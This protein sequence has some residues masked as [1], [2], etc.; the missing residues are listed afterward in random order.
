LILL[1]IF[2]VLSSNLIGQTVLT[3]IVTDT[4]NN[5]LPFASVYLSKTTMGTLTDNAGA[6]TI[7]IPQNSTYE[8]IVSCM[9]Y[10]SHSQMFSV[11]GGRQKIDVR[12][13]VN[14][15]MLNEVT[16]RSREK[17]WL[18]NYSQFVKMFLGETVNSQTCKIKNPGD[19]HL[20]IDSDMETLKG[21]SFKPLNIENRALGY[22]II[23]DLTDFNYNPRTGLLRFSGNHYFQDMKANKTDARKWRRNRLN[24]YYGSRMHFMRSLFSN[25]LVPEDFKI[26]EYEIVDTAKKELALNKPLLANDLRLSYDKS[27]SYVFF[28]KPVM[29]YFKDDHPELSGSLTGFQPQEL[30]STILFTDTVNVFSNG[31]FD[32][33]YSITWGGEM[34]NERIGDLLPFDFQPDNSRIEINDSDS[35]VNPV[36]KYLLSEQNSRSQDQIFVHL[37]RNMY[38][39]GDTIYFQAYIRNRFTGEFETMSVSL[40]ALL[41]NEEKKTIDS[42]RFKIGNSLSSGWMTM[43]PKAEPGQYHFVAFTS[44]MQNYGQDDAFHSDLTVRKI[45]RITKEDNIKD[46]VVDSISADTTVENDFFSL[47]FLPEGGNLVKGTE[48]RIGFNAVDFSGEPV[49]FEGLLKDTSGLILDTIR[50]GPYGPGFFT[51]NPRS[52]MYVEVTRGNEKEKIW[53]LP[54][55]VEAIACLSVS[56][57]GNRSFAVEIQSSDYKGQKVILSG[58]MNLTQIFYQEITLDKKHRIIVNTDQLPSGIVQVTLFTKEMQPV[59]ERLFYVNSDKNLKFTI[60][61]GTDIYR[62]G[63]ETELTIYVTDGNGQP[64]EGLFS[65]SVSDSILGHDARTFIPGIEYTYNYN[66]C[67][68]ANLPSVVLSHGLGNISDE[69][70]DL[71]MMVYG[72]SR[73]NWDFNQEKSIPGELIN[74]D[75]LKMKI[76][77]TGKNHRSDRR[78]D[79][80]SLEGPSIK[81]LLTNSLGEISLP[82]DSL[83]EITRSFTLMPDPKNKKRVTGAMFS[84]PYNENFFKSNLLLKAQPALIRSAFRVPVAAQNI[85]LGEEPIEIQEVIIK[86][87]PGTE[88]LYHDNYEETYQYADIRS[89]DYELLWSS[90]TIADAVR[91]LIVP[92]FMNDNIVV[93][94]P[95]RSFFGGDLPALIVLDGMPLYDN[96]WASVKTISTADVTSLTILPGGQASARYGMIAAGGVI[97]INTKSSDPSLQK[98]R[99]EWKLQHSDNKMLLPISL[100]RPEKDFYS[101]SRSDIETDPILRSRATIFWDP[102]VYFN[103]KEPIHLRFTNLMHQGPVIV[104]INGASTNNLVG[105]GKASYHVYE[106]A[107]Q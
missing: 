89:L 11:E 3:G 24:A 84:I 90:N 20:Y 107:G 10:K 32:N 97:F 29:I 57:E 18:N 104:T 69:D 103:G 101:P 78:L 13:S 49:W 45:K 33:S 46:E 63:Q 93:L 35:V 61:K 1:L 44:M 98:A 23:Y 4:L 2:L 96:G 7:N 47:R 6:Y 5:P 91:R 76:L 81:H 8:L 25:S 102:Q 86:A 12:L 77:Y 27:S 105:S 26:F 65:I 99:T 17:N 70:R 66:P 79:L 62:P 100:Y 41:F 88:R 83:T 59:A 71:L 53:R 14:L 9:G 74:Y 43:P 19:L 58:S 92:Y 21:F 95:P 15:I 40:Y 39:P 82:L 48:Q 73:Y 22:N 28:N 80:V 34:A 60:S 106:G 94:R 64:A 67:F 30:I 36:E 55:P 16:V 37:D 54:D 56:Q 75:L 42:S 38:K 51:C 68:P 85:S 50:S 72:W 52:G 87:K 31:Y